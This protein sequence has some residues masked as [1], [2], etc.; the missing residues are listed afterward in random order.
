LLI[1]TDAIEYTP[2]QTAFAK[3]NIVNPG[4]AQ[5]NQ[6]LLKT[7]VNANSTD[8]LTSNGIDEIRLPSADN[9]TGFHA[10]LVA[11][12]LGTGKASYREYQGAVKVIGSITSIIGSVTEIIIAEDAPII[13]TSVIAASNKLRFSVTNNTGDQMNI[14]CYIRYT[15]V[16][17]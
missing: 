17:A 12:N 14:N 16:L 2:G 4:D 15:H 3:F 10:R 9:L 8:V 1:G 6:I 11:L 5:S 13:T 7:Q